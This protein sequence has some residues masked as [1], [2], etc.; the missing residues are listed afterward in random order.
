[1]K[2][3]EAEKPVLEDERRCSS[4]VQVSSW[5]P[6]LQRA[7]PH[8][9]REVFLSAHKK[10]YPEAAAQHQDH[11]TVVDPCRPVRV[12]FSSQGLEAGGRLRCRFPEE[13]ETWPK[14]GD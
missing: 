4:V 7:Q 9:A 1:M 6:S 14:G 12:M 3:T 10:H 8:A 2:T 11:L 13:T 5:Y